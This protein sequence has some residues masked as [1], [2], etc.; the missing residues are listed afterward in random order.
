M[1]P[2][3]N[4]VLRLFFLPTAL[5]AIAPST[6]TAADQAAA[7][8]PNVLFIAIDDLND[9]TGALGGHPQAVTP[10]LDALA[11]R[12]V[13][14]TQAHCAAPACNPSRAALLTGIRPSTSGVY[15][16]SQ[17]WRPAMPAVVTLPQHFMK[18]GYRVV[19]GGK[20]Y[21]GR[22][23]DPQSWQEYFD[24]PADPAPAKLPANGIAGTGHFDWGPVT[25]TK[26]Q[27]ADWQVADWAIEQ[28]NRKSEQPFFIAAGIFRPHLPWYVP[29]E[30]FDQ[31]P[32]D[33][34]TIRIWTTYRRSAAKWP[35][36]RG[37]TRRS[38]SRTTGSGL[39]RVIW[40]AWPLPT[41][42]WVASCRPWP[43]ARTRTTPSLC[44]GATTAGT[45][46]RS[47]IGASS[48]SGTRRPA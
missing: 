39:C 24:R 21:H 18:H 3:P 25:E 27:M 42:A 34:V 45:W 4:I 13:L 1:L 30:Y 9:W 33:K 6:A 8:K 48:P 37:T 26:Q 10:N 41:S 23:K 29:Q 12:S 36:R 19:G 7:A 5:A 16:N 15:T 38:S 20:I 17:P 40:P 14:F 46:A 47:I 35:S 43:T 31:F 2:R 11:G 22:Y 32:A 44:S 28:I